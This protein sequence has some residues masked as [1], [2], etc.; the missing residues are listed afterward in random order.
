M[1]QASST[2]TLQLTLPGD[3]A[4]RFFPLFQ[5]GIRLK[6]R[7]GCSLKQ[8]LGEQLGLAPD[9]LEERVQTLFL[10]GKVVDDLENAFIRDG[11]VIAL[12]AALPGLAGATLRRGG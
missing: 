8:L 9:Y 1:N 12:S 10:D 5:Q 6:V 2:T 4:V 7:V 3:Q 11:S